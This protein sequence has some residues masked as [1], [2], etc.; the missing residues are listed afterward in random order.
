MSLQENMAAYIRTVMKR[1]HKSFSEFSEELGISRNALY[2]YS[3]GEGNPTLSTLERIS[4]KTGDH[5]AA[6]ISGMPDINQQEALL[7]LLEAAQNVNELDSAK[8]LRFAELFLEM[9]KLWDLE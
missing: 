8:R 3:T 5:P 9:V 7:L 4:E 2:G 6:I 1:E